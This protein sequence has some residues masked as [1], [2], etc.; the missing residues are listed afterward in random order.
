MD[1]EEEGWDGA[2]VVLAGLTQ[3]E[4]KVIGGLKFFVVDF[5]DCE[6]LKQRRK[7]R[8]KGVDVVG[9]EVGLG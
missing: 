7:S 6:I 9:D 2:E 3:A 4:P 8:G 5:G 1:K